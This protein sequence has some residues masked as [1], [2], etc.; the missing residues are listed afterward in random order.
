MKWI[1]RKEFWKS[2]DED[3][4]T[5]ILE[6]DVWCSFEIEEKSLKRKIGDVEPSQDLEGED[7]PPGP[8]SR[9][10]GVV[11][12]DPLIL[13]FHHHHPDG[14]VVTIRHGSSNETRT[15]VRNQFLSWG[16]NWSESKTS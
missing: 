10:Y 14:E 16:C 15:K 5:G 1:S 8:I 6:L 12:G 13:D 9:W 4:F 2:Y 7:N 11:E 3:I